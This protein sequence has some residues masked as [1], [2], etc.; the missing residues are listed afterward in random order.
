MF[1]MHIIKHLLENNN[2]GIK[3][4]YFTHNTYIK[5]LKLKN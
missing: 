5:K 4:H 3:D 2:K 1:T